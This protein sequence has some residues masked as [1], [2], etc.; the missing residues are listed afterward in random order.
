MSIMDEEARLTRI[1]EI[2]DALKNRVLTPEE[3]AHLECELDQNAQVRDPNSVGVLLAGSS[4]AYEFAAFAEK[5]KT[6]QGTKTPD[7]NTLYRR[8][9]ELDGTG[10]STGPPPG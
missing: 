3:I 5:L 4:A 6:R 1:C 10:P 7:F 2:L 8:R 9:A